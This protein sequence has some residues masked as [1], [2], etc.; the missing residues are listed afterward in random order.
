M[1]GVL[2]NEFAMEAKDDLE[3]ARMERGGSITKAISDKT[4]HLV[5]GSKPAK[6]DYGGIGGVGGSKHAKALEKS[7][8][9][10]SEAVSSHNH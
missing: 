1:R 3:D 10:L 5:L 9:M 4:S 8:L 6:A 2:T 7:M